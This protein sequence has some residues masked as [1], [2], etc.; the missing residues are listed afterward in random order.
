M[1]GFCD[2][3]TLYFT[4]DFQLIRIVQL[5]AICRLSPRMVMRHSIVYGWGA[6]LQRRLLLSAVLFR[7]GASRR[8]SVKLERLPEYL[9]DTV[10]WFMGWVAAR[11]CSHD[12]SRSLHAPFTTA[13]LFALSFQHSPYQA[14]SKAEQ[15]Q[16]TPIHFKVLVFKWSSSNFSRHPLY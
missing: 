2:D 14:A 15:L 16:Y 5:T 8:K 4:P 1:I 10:D 11:H 13:P 7:Y 6:E 3:D 12:A 9:R